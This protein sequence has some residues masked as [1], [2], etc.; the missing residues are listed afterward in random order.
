MAD[1]Y[2]A[3]ALA[4]FD[5]VRSDRA[6]LLTFAE[7]AAPHGAEVADVGCGP[8][9]VTDHLAVLGLDVVGYD[10]SSALLSRARRTYP[11]LAF[12]QGDLA[13]LGTG[14]A[15]L[16]GIVSRYS[17]IHT[18]LRAHASV[19][20][21]WHRVLRPRAPLLL[22]FFAAGAVES[23]GT[24]FDHAV[25]TAYALFPPTV[26]RQLT[27]AGFTDL[28]VTVRTPRPGAR[29]LDHATISARGSGQS[30]ATR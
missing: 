12:V 23:H 18:P 13:A 21:E 15:S 22:S 14:D 17:L 28:D 26:E 16:G 29:P 9:H 24:P 20:A 25:T 4:E 10:I 27:D 6:S 5:Q 30:V 2:T 7:R 19:F 11:S 1:E 8:G 3:F